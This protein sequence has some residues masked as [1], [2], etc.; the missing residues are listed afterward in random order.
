[1]NLRFKTLPEDE[2]LEVICLPKSKSKKLL[3]GAAIDRDSLVFI[4]G[5]FS[6]STV[7]IQGLCLPLSVKLDRLRLAD[8]GQTICFGKYEVDVGVVLM[9]AEKSSRLK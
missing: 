7:Q 6:A 1:V 5:D 2:L 9:K 4:R 3:I 8:F